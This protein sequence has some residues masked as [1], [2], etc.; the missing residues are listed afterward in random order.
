MHI[1]SP[2]AGFIDDHGPAVFLR[3]LI[4]SRD[5]PPEHAFW[6]DRNMRPDLIADVWHNEV[7]YGG[8]CH[9]IVE[10]QFMLVP[11]ESK[12]V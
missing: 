7:L 12:I 2:G 11:A 6:E 10:K 1:F 8:S 5:L 4:P 3:R 9:I